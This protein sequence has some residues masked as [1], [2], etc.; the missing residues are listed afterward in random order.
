MCEE[1]VV[2]FDF[3]NFLSDFIPNFKFTNKEFLTLST[4]T[5][6]LTY[7]FIMSIPYVAN[8]SI[9]REKQTR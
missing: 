2:T 5:R 8:V 1:V 9:D 6:L 7:S 3:H 4:V